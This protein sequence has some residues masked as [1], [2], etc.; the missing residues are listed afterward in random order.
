MDSQETNR[1]SNKLTQISQQ[2]TDE[3]AQMIL[4]WTHYAKSQ[5]STEGSNTDRVKGK[6]RRGQPEQSGLMDSWCQYAPLDNLKNQVRVDCH[7]ENLF[8]WLLRTDIDQ[9]TYNQSI[10]IKFKLQTMKTTIKNTF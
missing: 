7:G 6:R 3:Q 4:L 1:L 9:M 8:M 5:L 10:K 2:G